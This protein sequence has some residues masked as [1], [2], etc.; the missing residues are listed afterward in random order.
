[1]PTAPVRF[2]AGF[3]WGV[4][5][6]S[7]QIEGGA[8]EDGRGECIWDRFCRTPGKVLNGDTGD[9]ACDH[10]HRWQED[11]ALMQSLGV[12]AYR[13]SIAWPRIMPEGAGPVNER[14]LAFYDRLVDGLLGAGIVPFITLYH[15][16]LPQA[17]Q[18]RGGWPNRDVAGWF[19][20]YV[21]AVS[22]RLGDRVHHWI[23]LNEPFCTAFLGYAAGMHA[24]GITDREAG[25]KAA[26]HLLL[27]HARAIETLRRNGDSAT[28]VGITLDPALVQ[29][30]SSL[31]ADVEAAR[32]Y[33]AFMYRLFLEPLFKGR[34]PAEVAEFMGSELPWIEPGD[35]EQIAAPMDFLGVNYYTRMRIAAD[36]S[37]TELG[38]SEVVPPGAETTGMGWET[39]PQGLYELLRRIQDEYA[40]P[41]VYITEN[42]C[43]LDDEL[44]GGE[45]HDP[46]RVAYLRR[47]VVQARRTIDDG[48]PPKGY[49]V[50]SLY[51]NFE[52]AYGYSKRCGIVYIDYVHNQ[53][54]ILKDS[55]RWYR[56]VI[57]A[58]GL[59]TP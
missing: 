50:W 32:L 47:H 16:D 54:R 6:S 49:F 25:M 37:G 36:P 14:G 4:A 1:M 55:A 41:A 45:A 42:G 17:L 35:L 46:V 3:T 52:W 10:Y 43:A 56:G 5:T 12:Q 39:Y 33:D 7:F 48:I 24:P 40:P 57:A 9:V 28:Q 19:D 51:D 11:I 15:W 31:P 26:H 59:E 27:G 22:R 18:D 21:A 53:A 23:T 30:A 13:F 8:W 29:P 44:E 34:Y 20:D 2:P 38:G 58:N